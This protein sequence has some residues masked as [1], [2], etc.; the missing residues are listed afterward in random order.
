MIGTVSTEMMRLSKIYAPNTRF[1]HRLTTRPVA[2]AQIAAVVISLSEHSVI[3]LYTAFRMILVIK[4]LFRFQVAPPS[5]A[6]PFVSPLSTMLCSLPFASGFDAL[7]VAK[8]C[9]KSAMMS[10]MCSVPTEIRMRSSVT[11]L[12]VFS[13]S[14]SC[15]WVVVQ[16]WI[17]RV[18]ESPTLHHD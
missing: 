12:F 4:H 17:A 3:S 13:S 11:P 5:F 9:S 14:L 18:L 6:S 1:E 8:D 7:L 10:S 15:S 2:Y 16:G